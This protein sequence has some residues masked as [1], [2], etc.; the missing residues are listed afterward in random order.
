M[1]PHDHR[2]VFMTLILVSLCHTGCRTHDLRS[3][4]TCAVNGLQAE[5]QALVTLLPVLQPRNVLS[6]RRWEL[7]A[8]SDIALQAILS[9][10]MPRPS[11]TAPELD[12]SEVIAS[13]AGRSIIWVPELSPPEAESLR[14]LKYR[15]GYSRTLADDGRWTV[16]AHL[17]ALLSMTTE[18]GIRSRLGS[19]DA[20]PDLINVALFTKNYIVIF[21]LPDE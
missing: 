20:Q 2:A 8:E 1:M 21:A 19:P 15:Q 12:V 16:G 6:G 14:R 9:R 10:P 17:D 4:R 7:K 13:A 3:R 11:E 5:D 18:L